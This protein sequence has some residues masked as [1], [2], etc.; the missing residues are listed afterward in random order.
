MEQVETLLRLSDSLE[1][2]TIAVRRMIHQKPELAF[3]EYKTAG[4]E[5]GRAH[6]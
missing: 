5:I 4:L 6:V 2:H 3:E 1:K